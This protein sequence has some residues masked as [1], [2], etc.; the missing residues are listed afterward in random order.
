MQSEANS[1]A[2]VTAAGKPNCGKP[3]WTDVGIH[4]LILFSLKATVALAAS[5][6]ILAAG[7][8]LVVLAGKLFLA[9]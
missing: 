8:L 4:D 6:L 5:S 3:N 7:G 1:T 9:N 2:A